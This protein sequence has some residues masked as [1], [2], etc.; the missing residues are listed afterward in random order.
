MTAQG[1]LRAIDIRLL[2]DLFGMRDGYVLDFSNRTFSEF[3]DDEIGINIDDP[4]YYAE[5]TSKAK[6]LRYFL[7][8]SDNKL[9]VQTL[10][11]LWQYR[12]T[13]RRR[14]GGEE[15]ILN[16]EDEFY[17]I[18]ERL[19]G[20]RPRTKEKPVAQH[21]N[22]ISD[23]T[24]I[25]RLSANLLEVSALEP[26]ARGYAF[27]QFLKELFD[28]SGLD[29]RGSFRV[30]GEQI[31]GSFLLDSEL[32][33]LEAKWTNIKTDAATLLA[34]NAKVEGKAAWSRGLFVSNSGFTEDGLFAFGRGKR[35]VCMDGLDLYEILNNGLSFAE[36]L[37]K[38]VRLAAE[39]GYPFIPV[40]DIN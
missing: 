10:I 39:T 29:P 9:V 25:L 33:L 20:K 32:Y 7:R 22:V 21:G 17:Q 8:K 2:D 16:A 40:R 31:D 35:V 28:A 4:G 13:N 23:K 14:A 6:R 27:E 5:G 18:I 12:E 26:Q 30:R 1:K 24:L 3:F 36:V 34:F 37:S 15:T 19:G 38:K 11:A